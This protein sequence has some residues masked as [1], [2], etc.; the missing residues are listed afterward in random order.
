MIL[1]FCS[2]SLARADELEDLKAQLAEQSR[3]LQAM[4]QKLSTLESQQ[5]IQHD[6]IQTFSQTFESQRQP[7]VPDSLKWAENLKIGGDFRYRY[8]MIDQDGS[9]NRNRNRIRARIGITGKV[10]DEVELGFRLAT[11]EPFTSDKGDPVSTNQ[12]LDDAFSKKSIWLDLAYFKWIPKG[13][14]FNII[15]GKMENPL[16][17]VGGNQLIWDSDLTPEGIAV[18]YSRLFGEKDRLFFNGGA[19]Y[20]DEVSQG[21]DTSLWTVQGGLKHVFADHSSLLAGAGFYSYGNMQGHGPLIGSGFQG[22]SNAGGSYIS[23]YDIAEVF[24]EYAFKIDETP[25]AAFATYVKN[26]S[27]ETPQDTGWL[28][29]GKYG[30]CT[31]PG[32]WELSYDYRDLQADAVLGAFSDSDFVGGGTDGRGHRFGAVYQLAKNTQAGLNYFLNEKN[33]GS[34]DYNRLQL[35]LLFKF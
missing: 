14:N 12:S 15:G 26:T 3:I 8:E 10:S 23:D 5:T 29:G 34:R 4:Q 24:G 18:Q 31:A 32:T 25:A 1:F 16:Y 13:G 33:N 11:S 21:A 9:D 6:Q 30:K 22:N 35:D 17:R 20:I 28:V 7:A 19:F 2:I 27:A